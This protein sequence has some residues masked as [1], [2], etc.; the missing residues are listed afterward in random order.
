[1]KG[2][3]SRESDPIKNIERNPPLNQGLVGGSMFRFS[4]ADS[5]SL[6]VIA[7]SSFSKLTFA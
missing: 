2:Q 4:G 3:D 6:G 1:M 5:D 7:S